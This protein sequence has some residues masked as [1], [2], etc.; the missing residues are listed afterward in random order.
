MLT[1]LSST[2]EIM[3]QA[4]AVCTRDVLIGGAL[5]EPLEGKRFVSRV[6]PSTS[7]ID[8]VYTD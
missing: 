1:H 4:V 5:F 3:P 2:W 6:N 7:C 8:N